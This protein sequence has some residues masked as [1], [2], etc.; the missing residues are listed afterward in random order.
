M[1]K[2]Q[3]VE[4][5]GS[6]CL[7]VKEDNLQP[8][9]ETILRF[10][11]NS[12]VVETCCSLGS[13][14]K[15]SQVKAA[16]DKTSFHLCNAASKSPLSSELVSC[17]L[18]P[19]A[20]PTIMF[21]CVIQHVVPGSFEVRYPPHATG[22]HKLSVHMGGANIFDTPLTVEVIGKKFEGFS[23]SRGMAI[24]NACNLFVVGEHRNCITV[25][26]TANGR[27]IKSFGER[28]S[29]ILQFF[30]PAGIALTQDGC[31]IVVADFKNDRLQ[32]LTVE[33]AFVSAV[34]SKG[35]Q[36]L[37][38]DCPYDIAVHHNGKLFVTDGNNHRVQ[39]LNPD[40]TSYSH[41]FGGRGDRPGKFNHPRGITIDSDGMVYVADR[42]NN[43]VQKFTPK[44]EV[45]AVLDSKGEGG[46]RLNT[47]YGVYVDSND[48]LYVT[49]RD[50]NT[51]CAFSI[52]G[53]F[54]GYVGN[55]DGSS[56][57][58][59]RFITSD[60]CGRLYIS[61]ENGVTVY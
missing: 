53:Q 54:L 27:K 35:F 36:P 13:V 4:R 45:L 32:V 6:D 34:G 23:H 60:Q 1:M 31:H 2:R 16:G 51:V 56:F 9:E 38:F 48:I 42:D 3:M 26:N 5:M 15:C 40:L 55:D 50:S 7:Q 58:E 43:R 8:L 33:G 10:V 21:R 49:E 20:D 57:K 24:I 37:L 30:H 25:V 39:V 11:K 47:P 18:S 19:V 59:P 28:G 22:P 29:G 14:I 61:D 17:Q 41:R 52:N 12:S 44:G 46:S